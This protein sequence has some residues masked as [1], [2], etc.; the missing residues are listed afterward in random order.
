M[1]LYIT[2]A[3]CSMELILRFIWL[4]APVKKILQHA[5]DFYLSHLWLASNEIW[6][7]SDSFVCTWPLARPPSGESSSSGLHFSRIPL[8]GWPGPKGRWIFRSLHVL[9][10]S[11]RCPCLTH[12]VI[13]KNVYV[14][15]YRWYVRFLGRLVKQDKK[16]RRTPI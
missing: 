16:G 14:C 2:V 10:P 8:T 5:K 1:E 6:F 3:C 9:Y 11:I 7:A 12:T 13:Y 15:V 4:F